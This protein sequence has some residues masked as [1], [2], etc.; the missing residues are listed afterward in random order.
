MVNAY[1]VLEDAGYK[2]ATLQPGK[3]FL[4]RT[5][6]GDSLCTVQ[7]NPRVEH[8]EKYCAAV[9]GVTVEWGGGKGIAGSECKGAEFDCECTALSN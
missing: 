3:F 8:L 7:E 9:C 6:P 4:V 5:S 2:C 1:C